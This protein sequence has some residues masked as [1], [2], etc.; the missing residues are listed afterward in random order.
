MKFF[1]VQDDGGNDVVVGASGFTPAGGVEAPKHN[2]QYVD[3]I[4]LLEKVDSQW[5]FSQSKKDA[6]DAAKAANDAQLEGLK[7][8][9]KTRVS[10]LDSLV[11]DWSNATTEEKD[12][13]LC[14]LIALVIGKA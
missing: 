8:T 7:S 13:A 12:A 6:I 2:G 11:S 1:I 14:K 10:D 4:D 9:Q 5:T 3:S